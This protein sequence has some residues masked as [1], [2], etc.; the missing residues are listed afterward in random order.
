MRHIVLIVF[1]FIIISSC[2]DNDPNL[3]FFEQVSLTSDS[4][5]VLLKMNEPQAVMTNK[6]EISIYF[7]A[8]ELCSQ[9]E[10]P[11]CDVDASINIF[12]IHKKDTVNAPAIRIYRCGQS[13]P[14]LY[15][16]I[17]CNQKDFGSSGFNFT[18]YGNIIFN[19]KELYPYPQTMNELN[20]L[21]QNK[22]YYVRLTLLN[23]C[24]K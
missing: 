6:G 13:L 19:V 1:A 20:D 14:I 9:D 15:N 11:T 2:K 18:K 5:N 10:C 22:K 23:T 17:N 8:S 24:I 16:T 3:D 4:I 21:I 12:L 7:I